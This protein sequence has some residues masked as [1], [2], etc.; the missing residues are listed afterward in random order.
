MASV[1]ILGG[2]TNTQAIL[3]AA[4]LSH[5]DIPDDRLMLSGVED[6][7]QLDLYT[8]LPTY[9]DLVDAGAAPGATPAEKMLALAINNYAKWF[10]AALLCSRW[11][12]I[13]QLKT[14]GKTRADR[15]DRMDLVAM[16]ANAEA[17]WGAVRGYRHGVRAD[18]YLETLRRAGRLAEAADIGEV[19]RLFARGRT[20]A[21]LAPPATCSTIAA[22]SPRKAG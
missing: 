21:L 20:A 11:N 6:D 10:L 9:Q 12:A 8:K 4:G 1:D 16:Q 2:I 5:G 17:R 14:D 13:V 3:G 7:L 22:W 15:F 18:Q 19:F